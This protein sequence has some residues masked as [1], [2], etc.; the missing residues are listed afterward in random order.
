M[1]KGS[2]LHSARGAVLAVNEGKEL[3][4]LLQQGMF[5]LGIVHR[6]LEL[7]LVSKEQQGEEK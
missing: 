1:T 5:P 2:A 4:K 6:K 3:V 7:W